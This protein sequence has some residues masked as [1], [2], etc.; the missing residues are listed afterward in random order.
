MSDITN[1]EINPINVATRDSARIVL[2]GFEGAADRLTADECAEELGG[3]EINVAFD[4][5][6]EP[7][8]GD[9][10]GYI[11]S[12]TWTLKGLRHELARDKFF[13]SITCNMSGESPADDGVDGK[14][15]TDEQ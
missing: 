5:T 14:E 12:R 4:M 9:L 15:V 2:A 10:D 7:C 11:V 13:D 8:S 1:G 6:P 3:R